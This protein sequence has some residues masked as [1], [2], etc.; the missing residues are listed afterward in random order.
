[1]QDRVFQ[2]KQAKAKI[3]AAEP[4]RFKLLSM[5]LEMRSEHGVRQITCSN[6]NWHCTCD[7]FQERGICSHI[8]AAQKILETNPIGKL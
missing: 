6:G 3:Y 7:F 2:R 4:E 8:M 5:R 1:M